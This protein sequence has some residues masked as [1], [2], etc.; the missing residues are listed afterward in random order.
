MKVGVGA[1]SDGAPSSLEGRIAAVRKQVAAAC[2][3][4][5]RDPASVRI[6]GV[7]KAQPSEA[8]LRAIEAGIHEIGENYVQEARPK[9][10]GLPPVLKHFLGHVQTNK[11]KA[12]VDAFDVVQ[13]IDR[14]DAGRAVAKAALGAGRPVTTLVQVNVSPTERYGVAPVEAPRLAQQLREEGLEV[15]GVMAIGP[16]TADRAAVSRA[17]ELAASVFAKVGGSTLSIGMSSDWREAIA[18]G[19]TMLRLGTALFG[20][21]G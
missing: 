6:V 9:F 21:R 15:D 11:A 16:N 14:I 19:S 5:G 13:S 20:A 1:R 2:R 7:T 18:S 17:F 8:V 4:A 10:A 3:Q 12:I